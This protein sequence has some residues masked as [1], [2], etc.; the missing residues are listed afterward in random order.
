MIKNIRKIIILC[1]EDCK[2]RPS[3][4]LWKNQKTTAVNQAMGSSKDYHMKWIK[5]NLKTYT[6]LSLL[7]EVLNWAKRILKTVCEYNLFI[8]WATFIKPVSKQKLIYASG[9]GKAICFK[10]KCKWIIK[11]QIQR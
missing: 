2:R 11:K 5:I 10:S 9:Q 8:N 4:K 3:K 7:K 6:W 1:S